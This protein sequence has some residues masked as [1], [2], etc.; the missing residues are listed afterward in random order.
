MPPF[1]LDIY[2]K[3]ALGEDF[4]SKCIIPISEA[5][6]STNDEIPEPTWHKC[7]LKQD[8]PAQGEI[9][10]SFAIV[11]ADFSFKTPLKYVNLSE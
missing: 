4:I 8:S 2:D 3:D 10:I 11:E 5:K 7:R 9:L 1:V 6:Y